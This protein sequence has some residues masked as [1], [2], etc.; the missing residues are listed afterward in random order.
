MIKKIAALTLVFVLLALNFPTANADTYV[1]QPTIEDIL[2]EYQRKSFVS[3]QV[4]VSDAPATT[5]ALQKNQAE[6]TIIQE[7]ISDLQSAGYIAYNVVA[8][9]YNH[10]ENSLNTNFSELGLDPNES[11]IITIHGENT[12]GNLRSN[13]ITVLGAPTEDNLDDGSS[14]FPYTY[15]GVTY[16]MRYVTV[17]PS[18]N[19]ELRCTST[20][21]LDRI[22]TKPNY[23]GDI[24]TTLIAMYIDAV[25]GK[26]PLGTIASLLGEWATDGTNENNLQLE[27]DQIVIHAGSS[28]TKSYIQVWND[29]Y[30]IWQTRQC[31][32]YAYTTA[33]GSGMALNELTE[34]FE[35]VIGATISKTTYSYKYNNTNQRKIDAVQA[36]LANTA[37]YTYTGDLDFYLVDPEDADTLNWGYNS[38]PLFSHDDPILLEP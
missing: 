34:Q 23:I 10:L 33:Y 12:A 38:N 29:I 13:G 32:E 18:S 3:S 31:S 24:I 27:G 19:S 21:A 22:P 14:S 6:Q 5:Y 9:N 37:Y 17:T 30:D 26:V 2:N 4:S 36:F 7:T 20:Y 25:S 11:Y 16:Y 35:P 28:W 8:S 15:N 1:H